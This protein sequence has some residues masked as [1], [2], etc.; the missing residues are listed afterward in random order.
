MLYDKKRGNLENWIVTEEVFDKRYL[1][2]CEAIMSQGNGYMGIRAAT[3]E[4]YIGEVRNTFVGATFNRF[5]ESEVTELPNAADLIQME[6]E[7]NGHILNLD[8]G[9]VK[10]YSRDLNLRS[11]EL[12]RS[13]VWIT[14]GGDEISFKF[15]RLVSL[16]NKHIV[17]QKAEISCVNNKLD[18]R[19]KSGINAQMTNSGVQ[20]FTEG[21]KRLYEGEY[22]HL[23]QTTTQSKI[24]FV[25]NSVHSFKLDNSAYEP[26]SLIMMDRRKIYYEFKGFALGGQVLSIEKISSINTTRD[27]GSEDCS[28]QELRAKTLE[29]IKLES[30]KG[31]D[32]LLNESS[33]EWDNQVWNKT[34][35]EVESENPYDQLAIRFAQYHLRTMTPMHDNRMSVAAK[36]LSG[37]GYKGHSFWDAEIFVLPYF[38]YSDP[39]AARNLLE[40]RYLSLSG[41]R[42]KAQDNGYEGAMFPWESAWLEDGE[43]T[44]VWGAADI[45]TGKA[46]KIWSGFIEQHIS[47]DIA[48][49]AWQ[50][51]QITRDEE[52]MDMYGYELMLDIAKFWSSRLEWNE[53]RQRYHINNIMGPDEYKEHVNNNA[54]TNYMAHWTIKNAISYSEELKDKKPDIYERLNRVLELDETLKTWLDRIDRIYLPKPNEQ[55]VIP[56]D[57]TYLQKKLIPLAKYKNQENVGLIFKDYNL[58]QV[59]N[60]QV[61]KQADIMILF[62][63]LES[64]FTKEVKTANW[65]YYEPKTLHDS[66]LSLSTHSILASD[67]GDSDLAYELFRKASEIDLGPNMKT[68]D[69]GIHAA[70]IG[71]LWQCVVNGFGGVRLLDGEIR[72]APHL[73]KSWSRLK[74]PLVIKGDSL[75]IEVTRNLIKIIKTT[76]VNSYLE[77]N[78]N[79]QKYILDSELAI[80]Y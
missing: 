68:S 44:P 48:Y 77:I 60:I 33:E 34:P 65:S 57:D 12:T 5:D 9:I 10:G 27:M 64:L 67:L 4:T 22:L 41:A 76:Q 38:T 45:V 63:L 20:H 62:Y 13:F 59:N 71:G 79:N 70:S 25:L 49:A 28:L 7:L 8:S 30:S 69:H 14:P 80:N 54:F 37:E 24:D 50:Y 3:E 15:S 16:R 51:Y 47:S 53:E 19:L 6:I 66:S 11:G 31:Y 2:K 23:V 73:P 46:T 52:F 26:S 17:A 36:G 42:R 40:Y 29:A 35:I 58:E 56:Q 18:I 74:F 43:V 55:Q 32:R 1:G 39:A 61:S 78:I 75:L 21:E 72:I